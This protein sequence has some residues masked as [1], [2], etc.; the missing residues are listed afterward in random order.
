MTNIS[1]P[2]LAGKFP[3][4][5]F[6]VGG[7]DIKSALIDDHGNFINI[8]RTPTPHSSIDGPDAIIEKLSE[9][10]M[11][12]EK[13][14]PFMKPES[15]GLLMP[16]ILDEVTGTGIFSENL[17]WRNSPLSSLAEEALG[18]PVFLNHDVRG[19]ALAEYKLGEARIYKNVV[20]IV[21][22]TGIASSIFI[23]GKQY[24]AGGYAG[25]ISHSFVKNNNIVCNCGFTGCLGYVST[26]AAIVQLYLEATGRKASG[27][28]EVLALAKA[29]DKVALQIWENAIE[30]LVVHLSQVIGLLAP[31]AIVIG[32]GISE[33]G[34]D[35]LVPLSEQLKKRLTFHKHPLLFRAT[36]GENAGLIGAGLLAR[37]N[38]KAL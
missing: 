9:L 37:E 27:S 17:G 16:G 18:I 21:A 13:N 36:F 8:K 11:F 32:G 38:E 2:E 29:G 25:E 31:D 22:G 6:D 15:T 24:S 10:K 30:G 20:V 35:L 12:Y 14:F 26:P 23:N 5:V 28:K 4:L 3:V 1:I 34:N 19:A 7:T 33:A